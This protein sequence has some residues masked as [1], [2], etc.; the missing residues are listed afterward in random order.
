IKFKN[1]SA[2]FQLGYL[3]GTQQFQEDIG[4][5][6]L[7]NPYSNFSTHAI[8]YKGFLYKLGLLYE[9]PL[10]LAKARKEE[11]KP[12]RFVSVGLTWNGQNKF[13]TASDSTLF[14]EN[15]FTGD[16]DT[17]FAMYDRAGK[18]NLPSTL[19]F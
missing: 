15:G 1:L 19:G 14:L 3:Y 2:G 4:F 9:H 18:G 12:S 6:D 5:P 10:D 8:S 16:V 7:A 11:K 17:V 13:T